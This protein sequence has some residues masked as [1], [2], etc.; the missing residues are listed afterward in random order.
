TRRGC[1]PS[2]VRDT[3]RSTPSASAGSEAGPGRAHRRRIAR[4]CWT[5]MQDQF[6]VQLCKL[7]KSCLALRELRLFVSHQ[8]A[9]TH[10]P[11]RANLVVGQ[12]A[13]FQQSHYIGTRHNEE[14]GGLLRGQLRVDR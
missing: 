8:V 5:S 13:T 3:T 4:R 9:E 11:M 6:L 14:I 1:A 12:L 2:S 10:A 7:P